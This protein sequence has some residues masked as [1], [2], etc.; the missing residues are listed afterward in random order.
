MHTIICYLGHSI[1]LVRTSRQPNNGL[2]DLF[3]ILCVSLMSMCS[4]INTISLTEGAMNTNIKLIMK[5]LFT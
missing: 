2:S 1:S 3:I 5:V 4:V